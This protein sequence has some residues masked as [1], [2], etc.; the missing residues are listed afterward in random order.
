M[1]E[2]GKDITKAALILTNGGIVAIPTETV[3]G[4]GG[5]A[6]DEKTVAAIFSAKGRPAYNPLIV[7]IAGGGE[8]NK[9][10][11]A[12]P[13]VAEKLIERFWPG[14]LTLLL[15]KK[16]IIPNLVTAGLLDVG[17]RVPNHP[18]TIE[19][20]QMLPFP[21]AAP[22]ANPFGYI[23]PTS[24]AH[25]EQ[26]IGQKIPYILDGGICSQGVESTVVGFDK[27]TP[28]VYRLGAITIEELTKVA[29]PIFLYNKTT[30]A[31]PSPGMLPYHYSPL[32]PLYLTSNLHDMVQNFLPSE[33]GVITF[34]SHIRGYPDNH[35]VILSSK[36]SIR[37]AARNLY[38]ALHQLDALHL[39][40]I[41]AERFPDYGLGKTLNDR[42]VK[43]SMKSSLIE[44]L[45]SLDDN[46]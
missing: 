38:S 17:M 42:L 5:N 16:E 13:A 26:Q 1:A 30:D 25:V 22:S 20:L 21:L 10:V 40:R 15:P 43:A 27:N 12:V 29:G 8:L 33:T 46:Q 11:T 7:H 4:L 2:T 35:I 9:Y 32:T 45:G 34:H 39:K 31:P 37:E 41:I 23:S 44:K 18:L 24:P 28:V 3:Y 19:L 6:L 14:P 36:A